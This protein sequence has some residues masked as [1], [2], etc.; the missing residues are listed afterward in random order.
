MQV[1]EDDEELE[2]LKEKKEDEMANRRRMLLKKSDIKQRLRRQH[3]ERRIAT[4]AEE[5]Q[6]AK[7]AFDLKLRRMERDEKLAE[8]LALRKHHEQQESFRKLKERNTRRIVPDL[9]I[10][11]LEAKLTEEKRKDATRLQS[12]D[13]FLR[14]DE[15]DLE[16][17]LKKKLNYRR[18]LQNQQIN[19][20]RRQREL[21]EEKH[22]ER[23]IMEE[24]GETLHQEEVE[25][26]KQKMEKAALQQA[27]RDAFLKARQIWKSKRKE[28]L[29][30]EHDEIEKIIAEK[31]TLQKKE[32]EQKTDT[33]SGKE[34]MAQKVG[35]QILDAE[36]KKLERERICRDL[37]LAERDS[38]LAN[39]VIRLA[40][41]KKRMAKELMQDMVRSR[42]IAA[43][44][45]AKDDAIDAAF[46]RYLVEERRKLEIEER[47]K[48]EKRREEILKYGNELRETI[49][50]NRL[51][52][53]EETAGRRIKV[54]AARQ[55]GKG[56]RGDSE[57]CA[58]ARVKC[59][60]ESALNKV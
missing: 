20:R 25:A 6:R 57:V 10:Q 58:K 30:K 5:L 4:E 48:E 28:V 31:E 33:Q 8:E 27:E 19:N 41:E 42:V 52:F 56:I 21:E 36:F 60:S 23:K 15:E 55:D 43:E 32:A 13:T 49:T 22:R 40:L 47:K 26:E 16:H 17:L 39:E 54:E 53:E 37:F 11:D 29:K 44:R 3:I 51:R 35:K 45:K 24:A 7:E 50:K 38:E 1:R 46:A 34:A 14:R 12:S 9:V 18:E 59:F 2:R